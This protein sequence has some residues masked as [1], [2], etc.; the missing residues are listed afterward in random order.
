[1]FLSLTF[2]FFLENILTT[3]IEPI[4]VKTAVSANTRLPKALIAIPSP[5]DYALPTKARLSPIVLD[6]ASNPIVD[7]KFRTIKD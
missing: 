5:S 7:Y 2:V 4:P 1:M 3:L 6:A